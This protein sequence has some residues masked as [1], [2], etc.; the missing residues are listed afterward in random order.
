MDTIKGMGGLT[1]TDL[2][3]KACFLTWKVSIYKKEGGLLL[4]DVKGYFFNAIG[5]VGT[6][7]H[8]ESFS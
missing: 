6:S 1:G 7:N 2:V 4:T 3:Q 5:L 8:T